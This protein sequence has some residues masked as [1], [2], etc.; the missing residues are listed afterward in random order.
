MW[1]YIRVPLSKQQGTQT[2]P[3]Q[4]RCGGG[5]VLVFEVDFPEFIGYFENIWLKSI[6]K[7]LIF[8]WMIQFLYVSFYEEKFGYTHKQLLYKC[9]CC[10]IVSEKVKINTCFHNCVQSDLLL[11]LFQILLYV[12]QVCLWINATHIVSSFSKCIFATIYISYE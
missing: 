12:L 8:V 7:K 1:Q 9:I 6:C 3:K 10:I 5:G 2:S 4:Y 11:K